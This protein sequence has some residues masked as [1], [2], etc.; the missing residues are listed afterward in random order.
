[1][2]VSNDGG[3]CIAHARPIGCRSAIL[4]RSGKLEVPRKEKRAGQGKSRTGRQSEYWGGTRPLLSKKVN[5]RCG[6]K[7][8]ATDISRLTRGSQ[9]K[10]GDAERSHR[11]ETCSKRQLHNFWQKRSGV[12]SPFEKD[13]VRGELRASDV[14]SQDK[15]LI[16]RY[17]TAENDLPPGVAMTIASRT[18]NQEKSPKS[19]DAHT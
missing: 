16:G 6:E 17:Q 8:I 7:L 1:V 9:P 4:I 18:S 13:G 14:K 15:T 12:N 19:S 5:R 3:N 10:H 11:K 2:R